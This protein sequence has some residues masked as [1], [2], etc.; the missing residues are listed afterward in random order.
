VHSK[1]KCKKTFYKSATGKEREN[2]SPKIVDVLQKL[3][4][5]TYINFY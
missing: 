3:Q 4:E 2:I 1:T 5:H